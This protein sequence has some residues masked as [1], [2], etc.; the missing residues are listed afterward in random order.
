MVN[1]KIL[2]TGM[3][4]EVAQEPLLP[5][6]HYA[7]PQSNHDVDLHHKVGSENVIISAHDIVFLIT[8]CYKFGF[9]FINFKFQRL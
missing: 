5:T 3:D 2:N 6:S 4:N 1:S 8:I 7:P 9:V